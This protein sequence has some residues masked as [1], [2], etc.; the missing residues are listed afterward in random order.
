MG[1]EENPSPRK[2]LTLK[3]DR[4]AY[5]GL[6]IARHEGKVVMIRGA[7]L[8][9][10]TVEAVIEEEKRDFYTASV[11]KIITPSPRRI[12][13][14]CKFYGICG[15]CH[16][17]HASYEDQVAVK[18]D[19]LR[20]SLKRTAKIDISLST[21]IMT[22]K[23]WNYRY[24]GQFKIKGGK[25]GFYRKKSRDL[26]EIDECPLMK[27]DI[28]RSLET[29]KRLIAGMNA[30]EIH[31]S[32]GDNI[33]ALLKFSERGKAGTPFDHIASAF[34]DSGFSG[35]MIETGRGEILIYGQP[36]ITLNLDDLKYTVSGLS[37]FQSNYELNQLLV[38]LIKETLRPFKGKRVLDLYAGAGNFSLPLA[39]DAEVIAVEESP[40]AVEDGLRNVGING[41]S[42]C[43]F[44]RS[45]AEDFHAR[46]KIDILILDPPRPGLTQRTIN[47]VLATMPERIVYISC[48]PS[49][50]SRDIKK[51]SAIYD[52]ESV[53]MVDLFPQTYHIES[54]AF[55]RIR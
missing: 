12:K 43:Q 25:I 7:A 3:I 17:Q 55:L 49:T 34:L 53:R 19:I 22:D 39:G 18:E 45:S 2:I 41:T 29:A 35:L 15:G 38:S 5:G 36:Y 33:I 48:D 27:D 10:E 1:R 26:V 52:I 9:E 13:P 23:P 4:P 30:Q 42:N 40:Y 21:P 8:P 51:L 54:L 16:L 37:F 11:V 20:D 44:I 31:I 46:D 6:Y 32:C 14:K 50:F 47:N 24:R 28:N